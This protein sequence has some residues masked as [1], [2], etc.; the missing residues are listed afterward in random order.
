MLCLKAKAITMFSLIMEMEEC[1]PQ[2]NELLFRFI[3]F[4][5]VSPFISESDGAMEKV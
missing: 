3:A 1:E 4:L 2:K 5:D